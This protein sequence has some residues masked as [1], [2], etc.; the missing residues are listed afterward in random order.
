[1]QAANNSAAA[2]KESGGAEQVLARPPLISSGPAV[3]GEEYVV[4]AQQE[5]IWAGE[6]M[7]KLFI[8]K[9]KIIMCENILDGQ[10]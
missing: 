6:N 9:I 4:S 10:R 2:V 3:N 5:G 1:M 8:L 7:V